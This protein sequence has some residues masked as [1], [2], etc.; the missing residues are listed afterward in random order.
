MSNNVSFQKSCRLGDNVE[1][2]FRAG[3]ATY[4]ITQR[5]RIACWKLKTIN[6]HSE[7]VIIIAFPLQQYV[8]RTH[9]NVPL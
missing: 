4:N 6:K 2:Y 7:Y 9:R 1:K 5:M 8:A 3:Q